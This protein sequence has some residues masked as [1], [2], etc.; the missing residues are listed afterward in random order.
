MIW[1]SPRQAP[2]RSSCKILG[3]TLSETSINPS[4]SAPIRRSRPE[5]AQHLLRR[6][7]NLRE[8][9][10]RSVAPALRFLVRLIAHFAPFCPLHS[11]PEPCC[12]PRLKPPEVN[13]TLGSAFAQAARANNLLPLGHLGPGYLLNKPGL[14]G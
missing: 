9:L 5:P 13:L 2:R 12:R 3:C 4:G 10:R 1:S 14:L 6:R 8:R 11:L 7:V